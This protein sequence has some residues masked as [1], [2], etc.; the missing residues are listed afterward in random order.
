MDFRR[1]IIHV[2]NKGHSYFCGKCR[3]S[4]KSVTRIR[5]ITLRSQ[6]IPDFVEIR[7]TSYKQAGL[8]SLRTV[9][10]VSGDRR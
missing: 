9:D 7:G 2:I 6:A 4:Y 1:V 8:L 10:P 5:N 3:V